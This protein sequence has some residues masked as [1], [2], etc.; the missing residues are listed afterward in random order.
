MAYHL[1]CASIAQR[2]AIVDLGISSVNGI[3]D[4]GLIQFKRS[5]GATTGLRI[6]FRLRTA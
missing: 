5:I 6:D 3:P 1:T 4:D 2:V